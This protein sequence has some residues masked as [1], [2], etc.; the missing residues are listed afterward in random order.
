MDHELKQDDFVKEISIGNGCIYVDLL[1][2]L[3]LSG[4]LRGSEEAAPKSDRP[5]K[6]IVSGHE[7]MV[8]E[9]LGMR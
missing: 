2:G 4:P 1:S 3:R 5:R 6:M 7:G 9:A 8:G